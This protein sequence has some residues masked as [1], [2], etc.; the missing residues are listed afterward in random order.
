[1]NTAPFVSLRN[2]PNSTE[3]EAEI[4][5]RVERLERYYSRITSCRV[6]VSAPRR[7]RQG[8]IYH[9]RIDLAVPGEDIVIDHEAELDHAHEDL[10]VAIRDA[11]KAARRK[12]QDH[13]RRMRG[14]VK[15]HA[16]PQ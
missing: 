3:L 12:L 5:E 7:H 6:T 1:M 11:F 8:G 4:L 13:A 10:R 14:D 16:T 15:K 2:V 9:V